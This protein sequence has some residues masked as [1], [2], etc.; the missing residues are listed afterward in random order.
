MK[1]FIRL[2]GPLILGLFL[3][4]L[5][6]AASSWASDWLVLSPG[7]ALSNGKTGFG[8]QA[9]FFF[10]PNLGAETDAVWT[11]E[12]CSDCRLAQTTLTE[13]LFYWINPFHVLSLYL[14]GGGGLG[15]FQLSSPQS[16]TALLP[17]FDIGLGAVLWPGKHIGFEIET[18]WFFPA[19]G[20]LDGNPASRLETNRWF[21]AIAI[22]L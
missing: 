6:P 18:R 17:V 13:N 14:S 8:G 21:A 12:I 15:L 2:S 4:L 1:I 10:V 9:K 5:C 19:G 11:P 22:P 16:D 7:V 20:G 3:S